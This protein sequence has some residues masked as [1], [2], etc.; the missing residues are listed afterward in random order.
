MADMSIPLHSLR[1]SNVLTEET[2]GLKF[3]IRPW[4]DV[5][6]ADDIPSL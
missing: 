4:R 6:T 5:H 1:F 3:S 2:Y